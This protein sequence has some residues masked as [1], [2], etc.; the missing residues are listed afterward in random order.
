MNSAIVR[1][2]PAVLVIAA[3]IVAGVRYK[4]EISAWFAPMIQTLANAYATTY[5]NAPFSR[6]I[7]GGMPGTVHA[8]PFEI[9]AR[10]KPAMPAPGENRLMLIVRD[11]AG[12][13]LE[14]ASVRAKTT[15]EV[16]LM[17]TSPGTYEGSLNLD[18][19]GAWRVV[20]DVRTVDMRHADFVIHLS[21]GESG[22]SIAST[23]ANE[24][25]F[26]YWTCSMHPSVRSE[27]AGKCPICAMDL[28]PVTRE[29]V[30]SGVILVDAQR[31]QLIGVKTGVV[32]TEPVTKTIRTV[33][34]LLA[35]ETR[36]TD[37]TLKLDAW[38]G[39]V[40]A[41]FTGKHVSKGDP[42]FTFYSPEL[43]S[44]QQ[45]LLESLRRADARSSRVDQLADVAEMRLRLWGI[46][47]S[48]IAL[49]KKDGKP[50]E[51]VPF[52]SPATGTVTEKNVVEGSAI[53]AGATLYRIA[54]LSTL[55]IEA[56]F[57]WWNSVNVLISA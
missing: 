36:L 31:Q 40:Q 2:L 42:L 22:I 45:E 44:A 8:G 18:V 21:T 33:G 16:Q 50:I 57:P 12:I 28:V 3:L 1:W 14:G 11:S 24:G 6:A 5:P 51:Y 43:W 48:T 56:R 37:I 52:L 41:D 30:E 29:E 15:N 32:R 13:P 53:E 4:S 17:E 27:G 26:A 9:E 49:L 38:I 10:W 35:D 23:S 39:T 7:A 47:S 34:T 46:D 20:G 55:W 19:E 25:E 54:D